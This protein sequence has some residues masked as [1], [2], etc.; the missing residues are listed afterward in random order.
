MST[1][2]RIS[3]VSREVDRRLAIVFRYLL[4][5]A[6]LTGS[7]SAQSGAGS[8][9]GTVKDPSGSAIP[10][11]PVRVVNQATGAANDT[12]ANSSGF[13]SV[14][15]LFAGN[16]TITFTA[17]GMKSYQATIALQ[18]AQNAVLNPSLT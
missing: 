16:Y 6:L 9:Q 10:H 2:F 11:C 7:L 5:G 15:G 18:D 13:Y 1:S 4:A 14:P 3:N 17:P 12:V 8:I